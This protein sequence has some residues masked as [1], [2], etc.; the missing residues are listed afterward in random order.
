MEA[1]IQKSF[2][3][4]QVEKELTN[5]DSRFFFAMKEDKEIGY[6]KLNKEQAQTDKKFSSALEIERIYV[7]SSHQGLKIGQQLFDFAMD[8]ANQ[9]NYKVVW[10]GVWDQNEKAIRFYT[11]NGFKICGS[12]EFLLG[13][14]KQT[15]ILMK[16]DRS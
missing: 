9:E 11:K 15:D 7:Q 3:S 6:L 12:H 14:D 4:E 10:L 2:S 13:T 8:I 16:I 1:Y 5:P